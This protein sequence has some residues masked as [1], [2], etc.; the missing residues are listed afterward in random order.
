MVIELLVLREQVENMKPGRKPMELLDSLQNILGKNGLELITHPEV[1]HF[2][3]L[4]QRVRDNEL[5]TWRPLN[6]QRMTAFIHMIRLIWIDVE[7]RSRFSEIPTSMETTLNTALMRRVLPFFSR[8]CNE[9]ST[10]VKEAR[11]MNKENFLE[12]KRCLDWK[13]PDL[14]NTCRYWRKVC[15]FYEEKWNK[16]E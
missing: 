11:P 1:T 14:R 16:E 9:Y 10:L 7:N 15:Y 6:S 12:L 2:T 13:Y 5:E 8:H 3:R 4:A